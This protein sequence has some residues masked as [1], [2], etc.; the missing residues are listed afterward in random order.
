MAIASKYRQ[1]RHNM[2]FKLYEHIPPFIAIDRHQYCFPP[3]LL[4][5]LKKGFKIDWFLV[6]NI[7]VPCK[8]IYYKIRKKYR[9]T[10]KHS[11]YQESKI[12]GDKI[13]NDTNSR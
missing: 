2:R 3:Q 12:R 11:G 13:W 8:N 4:A 10:G 7:Q 9:T 6:D 5:Q 1:N